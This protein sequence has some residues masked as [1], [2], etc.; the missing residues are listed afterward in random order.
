MA[1]GTAWRCLA[2]LSSLNVCG[3][4]GFFKLHFTETG[5]MKATGAFTIVT[6]HPYRTARIACMCFMIWV[7]AMMT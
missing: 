3:K 4:L 2:R 5:D 7:T 6:S 1:V